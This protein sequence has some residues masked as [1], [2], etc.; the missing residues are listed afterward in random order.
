MDRRS[1]NGESSQR[2][3]RVRRERVSRKKIKVR[4]K[5]HRS[6]N[7][8]FF[9]W[10][11]APEGRKSRLAKASGAEPA[12]RM[13]DEK[14]HAAVARSSFWSQNVKSTSCSEHLW[15]LR[16]KKCTPSWREA[17]LEAKMSTAPQHRTAFASW[18]VEKV[19][20]A[21]ARS[22]FP[23]QNGKATTCSDHF[24]TFKRRFLWQRRWILH[25][26]KSEPN[27]WVLKNDGRRRMFEE[28][29]KV[30]ETCPSDIWGGHG[31]DF[32]EGGCILEH[33]ICRFAR[34]ILCD[35]CSTSYDMP[36]LFRLTHSLETWDRRNAKRT[37]TRP[38][39]LHTTCH[40]WMSKVEEVSQDC[41][42]L[43]PFGVV[44]LHFLKEVWQNCCVSELPT[45]TF[46][47]TLA[48]LF[49]FR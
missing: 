37:G 42:L 33:Q 30:Q 14:L 1:N 7:T 49:P 20:A 8:V 9:Q 31:A 11:V 40:F 24:W 16:C 19:H 44:N 48:S 25:R 39:A 22:T 45:T 3:E 28:D 29:L 21:V 15:K 12:G 17:H 41:F 26:V 38:S 18:D 35:R 47:G 6:R 34:M 43:I 32:S 36:S 13:R 46:E 2:R 4:E 23:S 27:V 5:V 10:F